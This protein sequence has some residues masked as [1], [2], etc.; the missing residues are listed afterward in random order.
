MRSCRQQNI[1]NV[2]C[3][4]TLVVCAVSA[5]AASFD[6][7]KARTKIEH[8]ICDT[9]EISKLD[10]VLATH[11]RVEQAGTDAG[12][13]KKKQREWLKERNGCADAN[14]VKRAYEKRIADVVPKDMILYTGEYRYELEVSNDDN[15]CNHMD[16]VYK[17]YFR[18]PWKVSSFP[19]NLTKEDDRVKN[20]FPRLPGL[21]FDAAMANQMLFSRFPSSPE[22]EA[23]QWREGRYKSLLRSSEVNEPVLVADFDIDNDGKLDT[24]IHDGFFHQ[25]YDVPSVIYPWGYD[26]FNVVPLGSIDLELFTGGWLGQ[27][28]SQLKNIRTIVASV[29]A[30]E[31]RIHA[32]WRSIRPFLL[33]GVTYFS[34]AEYEP[35]FANGVPQVFGNPYTAVLKYTK[36]TSNQQ[37]SDRPLPSEIET[38]CRFRMF[39]VQQPSKGK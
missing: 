32:G 23:I 29:L 20:M 6:C 31:T 1:V 37:S 2:I 39:E 30:L 17:K 15:V 25:I 5:Q 24:V 18:T 26:N 12:E 21:E 19:I 10:E 14:C 36:D 7:A 38:I 11:Y 34:V 35:P 8:I 3:A 22:F 33:D 9:P 16:G 28:Y 13:L 4:I 27:I